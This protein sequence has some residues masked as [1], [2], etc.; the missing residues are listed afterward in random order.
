[1]QVRKLEKEEE[2]DTI[3]RKTGKG[4]GCTHRDRRIVEAV[5]HDDVRSCAWDDP[6]ARCSRGGVHRDCVDLPLDLVLQLLPKDKRGGAV[7]LL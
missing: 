4:N 2:E 5:V 1:M 3:P 6:R 7:D